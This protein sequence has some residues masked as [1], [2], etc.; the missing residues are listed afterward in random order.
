M[1]DT[2]ILVHGAF[3]DAHAFDAIAPLLKAQGHRVVAAD[4][5]G[6]GSDATSAKSITLESYVDVVMKWVDAETAPVILVGHS[7]AGMVVSQVAERAPSKVKQ[8]ILVAAYLPRSGQSLEEL[9][10]TDTESL[11]GP[12]MVFAPDFSTVT[13]RKEHLVESLAAD[14]PAAV[15][16]FIVDG[17][18][19]EP[20]AP[21]QGKATLTNARFGSVPRSY[22]FTTKD[23]AVG[24][25]L[26][27]QMVAAWPNTATATLDTS[28]L[29]FLAQPDA[30]VKA[31]LTLSRR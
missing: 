22:I 25:T 9:A 15:Q 8:V 16:R 26:Q 20:L 28:H 27:Q 12:N 7:M 3:A 2:F 24:P 17:H 11:V 5:P 6:H 18:K 23:R 1:P 10:K 14:V 13:I 21:F 31:L 19:P 29:P 30:F 4:L